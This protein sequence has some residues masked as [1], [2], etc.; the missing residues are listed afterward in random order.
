MGHNLLDERLTALW[1]RFKVTNLKVA[2]VDQTNLIKAFVSINGRGPRVTLA[3]QYLFGKVNEFLVQEKP[4]TLVVVVENF[5]SNLY[6]AR[7]AC[8]VA[9]SCGFDI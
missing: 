8:R 3:Q 7:D 9:F 1:A 5:F 6:I 2:P 4:T